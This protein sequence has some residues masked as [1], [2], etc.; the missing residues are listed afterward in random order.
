[1]KILTK[2]LALALICAVLVVASSS[3]VVIVVEGV[4]APVVALL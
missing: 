2:G 3:L 4:E 1:M